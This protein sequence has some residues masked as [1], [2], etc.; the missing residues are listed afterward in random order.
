MKA[1]LDTSV[2]IATFY[3]NHQFHR[4]SI[5]LFLRFKKNEVCCGAHSL[6]EIYSALTGRTGKDRVSGD[7]AMLFL[8]DV[9]ERLT[10]VSLDDREYFKAMEASSALGIAGGAIYDAVLGHCA[11]KAKAQVIYTWNTKDFIRLGPGIAG[12]VKAPAA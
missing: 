2:L 5:D 8:G 1:L 12:R 4:P 7:E 6:A 9:R 11:V 3:A 10:I